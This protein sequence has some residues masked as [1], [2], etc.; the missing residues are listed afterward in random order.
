MDEQLEKAV[1]ES[2]VNGHLPCVAAFKVAARLKVSPVEVGHAANE[3]KVRIID[4][5]LGCFKFAKVAHQGLAS[6]S[7]TQALS[8]EVKASAANG[9]ISCAAALEIAKRLRLSR[10]K[11]GDAT[12][13]LGVKLTGCQLGCFP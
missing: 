10:K 3:L 8:D 5:Q 1:Q 6:F 9:R 11:V 13:K 12:N 7:L 2:L 4:C